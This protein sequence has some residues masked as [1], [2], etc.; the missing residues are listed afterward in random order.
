MATITLTGG[1]QFPETT[2]V[3]VYQRSQWP[4]ESISGAPTGSAVA[5]PATITAGQATVTVPDGGDYIAYA[6]VGGQDRY[7]SFTTRQGPP[8]SGNVELGYVE[9]ADAD[10]STSTINTWVDVTGLSLTVT[11]DG[12]R[13]IIV[14]A[15]AS[16]LQETA[17]TGVATVA[18]LQGATFIQKANVFGATNMECPLHMR[19]RLNLPAGTYTFKLQMNQTAGAGTAKLFCGAD[20]PAWLQVVQV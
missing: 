9:K 7:R 6:N 10:F 17:T 20:H 14:E 13:P 18:L 12:S 16:T 5:G 15:G 3:S 8:A 19:K 11:I 4:T 1:T 2:S